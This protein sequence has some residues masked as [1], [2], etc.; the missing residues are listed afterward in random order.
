[1]CYARNSIN[2]PGAVTVATLL[3]LLVDSEKQG[4]SFT[5]ADWNKLKFTNPHIYPKNPKVPA[6]RPGSNQKPTDH[7]IDY[8][9][10]SIARGVRED[11]LRDLNERF[12]KVPSYDFDLVALYKREEADAMN[13]PQLQAVLRKLNDDIQGVYNHWRTRVS[14]AEERRA[15]EGHFTNALGATYTRFLAIL[16][17]SDSSHEVVKRWWREEDPTNTTTYSSSSFTTSFTSIT[18][19]STAAATSFTSTTT[20]REE[21]EA[22]ED[23]YQFSH[24][25]LLRASAAFAKFHNTKFVWYVAGRQ[26]GFLKAR[27]GRESVMLRGDMHAA[28][29]VDGGFVRKVGRR[30]EEEG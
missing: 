15:E 23:A 30:E 19:T 29:K 21:E 18:S 14:V 2:H 26:L 9:K 4:Y 7:I 20:A 5:E 28:L 22:V 25:K 3:G 8:L 1:M 10:F 13:S 24:W 27:I 16:P 17:P 11:A 12:K 6:Y